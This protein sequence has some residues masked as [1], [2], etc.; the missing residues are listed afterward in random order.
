MV[1]ITA[2]TSLRFWGVA[3]SSASDFKGYPNRWADV[4]FVFHFGFGQSD[5]VEQA[6]DTG[7]V[8]NSVTFS[9]KSR[10]LPA[11]MV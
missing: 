6:R 10:R 7:C 11:M 2:E 3:G 4:I 1:Q 9:M 8:R 5:V